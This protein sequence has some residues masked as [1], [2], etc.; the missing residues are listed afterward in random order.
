MW[1]GGDDHSP[2]QALFTPPHHTDVPA[3]MTDLVHFVE[4]NNL[5]PL[6]QAAIA[7]AHFETIHPFPDGNGRVGRALM[8]AILKGKGLTRNVTVP[9]SAGLLADIDTYFAA[10][11][12]YRDGDH[13][14]IV[15]LSANASFRAI[16]NGRTLVNDVHTTRD[17]WRSKIRARTDA[18]VWP[19]A[20]LALRQP[21][22][23]SEI[24][25]RELGV[26]PH[27]A[28]TAIEALENIGAIKKVAG[29]YRNRK[30]AATE[31]LEALDRFAERAGRRQRHTP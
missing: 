7:H 29:N 20:D 8:H 10:L 9:V 13:E 15:A 12:A 16:D 31:V 21:V 28:N 19:L 14:P 4:R 5:P 22:L 2:H 23:D 26:A 1:I 17:D 25:Q 30:W 27:N 18:T 3:A 6:A 11:T 24:V